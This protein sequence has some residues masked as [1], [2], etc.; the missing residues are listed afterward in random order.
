[1]EQRVVISSSSRVKL[2]CGSAGLNSQ[3]CGEALTVSSIANAT[4]GIGEGNLITT[5]K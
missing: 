3:C 2:T 1:M 4:G 5:F